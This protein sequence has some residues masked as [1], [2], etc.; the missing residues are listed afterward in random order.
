MMIDNFCFLCNT[1]HIYFLTFLG[2]ND[3]S[4]Y[5]MLISD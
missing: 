5:Y 1:K 3:V 4:V 2:I